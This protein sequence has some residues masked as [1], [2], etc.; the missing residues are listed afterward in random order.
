M[1]IFYYY[2]FSLCIIGYGYFLLSFLKIDTNS[3]GYIGLSGLS[4]LIFISYSTSIFFAHDYKFNSFVIL[5]GLILFSFFLYKKFRF[6]KYDMKI[7]LIFFSLFITIFKI[8]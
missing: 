6:I 1:L 3:L 2:V 8:S 5:L 7:F 4:F